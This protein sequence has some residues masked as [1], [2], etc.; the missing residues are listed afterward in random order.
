MADILSAVK[1]KYPLLAPHTEALATLAADKQT[2]QLTGEVVKFL[3]AAV[4]GKMTGP[5]LVEFFNGFLAPYAAKMSPIELVKI[6]AKCIMPSD[7]APAVGLALLEKYQP[8]IILSKN[9]TLL[10]KILTA[11]ISLKKSKDLSEARTVID[12]IAKSLEDPIY[13]HSVS[14]TI[15]GSFHLVASDL[16]LALGN[17]L[18]F[19]AHLLKFLTYSPLGEIDPAVL[20]RTTKQAG[21]IALINP[22]INDFGDLLSLAVFLSGAPAWLVDFL[23]AIHL[24]DFDGFEKALKSHKKELSQEKQLMHQ[25]DTSLRRKLTMISLAELAS[26]LAPERNRRLQFAQ[27]STHCRV[28][29]KEVEELVMTTMGVGKLVTGVIDEVDSSVVITSVKPRVLDTQR[30]VILKSRIEN[31]ANRAEELLTQM[32]ELTPELLVS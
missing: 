19:Y 18:E 10:A 12:G 25:I 8:Q 24:G 6:L 17:D 5:E 9:S 32:T 30:V 28:P 23:R 27:I 16:Y 14:A 31:W 21:I 4:A 15:R 1:S 11:E 29:V 13:A 2:H 22:E 26:F 20:A 3:D 7:V